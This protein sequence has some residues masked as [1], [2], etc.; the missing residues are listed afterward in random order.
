MPPWQLAI[1]VQNSG[2]FAI[3]TMRKIEAAMNEAILNSK[4]WESDNTKVT[5]SPG[6]DASY[7]YLYGNH[8]ATVG[9]TFVELYSCGYKTATT[10]SRLN[11]ILSEHGIKGECVFQRKGEWFV[12]KFVGQAG[13]VPVF[14]EKEFEEGM[15]FS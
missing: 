4:D 6:R 2:A 7:V 12:H 10:K 3:L 1:W 8:I 13:T 5:Y 11:A 9:D 15:I 14:V